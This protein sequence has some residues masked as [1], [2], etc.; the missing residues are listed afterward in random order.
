MSPMTPPAILSPEAAAA[1]A[2]SSRDFVFLDTRPAPGAYAAG[3]LIGAVDANPEKFLSRAGEP[4]F[5]PRQGGR[6]P[7]PSIT[8]WARTLGEWGIGP[9]TEVVVYDETDG[10]NAAAPGSK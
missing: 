4:G 3:H 6:H 9:D 7:L 1:R 8:R 10:S 5:D 2:A